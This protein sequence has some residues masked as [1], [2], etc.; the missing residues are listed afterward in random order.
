M[1]LSNEN[2]HYFTM[3]A[4]AGACHVDVAVGQHVQ[5]T[6]IRKG[7]T[8]RVHALQSGLK[9]GSISLVIC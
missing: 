1:S 7:G 5:A 2:K 3:L 6:H 4:A 9:P 8:Q